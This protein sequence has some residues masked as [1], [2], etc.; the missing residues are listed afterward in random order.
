MNAKC[1]YYYLNGGLTEYIF[2]YINRLSD[3]LVGFVCLFDFGSK[4]DGSILES[5]PEKWLKFTAIL[6]N[7]FWEA[8]LHHP[9]LIWGDHYL[10]NYYYYEQQEKVALQDW[11]HRR[12]SFRKV[13]IENLSERHLPSHIY[14]WLGRLWTH[15]VS[16][17]SPD[18]EEYWSYIRKRV[19]G[20]WLLWW[21]NSD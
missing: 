18:F 12:N 10:Y 13:Q 16:V 9:L 14:D 11:A 17:Q 21:K 19:F 15:G 6:D 1:R 2:A 7:L 5:Q 20:T 4:L 3:V 8:T